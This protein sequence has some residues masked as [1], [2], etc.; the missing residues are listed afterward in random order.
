MPNP[1]DTPCES[2]IHE[3]VKVYVHFEYF[4]SN[5]VTCEPTPPPPPPSR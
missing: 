4:V 1:N 5:S 2:T 3:N